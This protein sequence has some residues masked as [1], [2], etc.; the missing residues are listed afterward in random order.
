MPVMP[1]PAVVREHDPGQEADRHI[2]PWL[3]EKRG[4][5]QLE[6]LY[7]SKQQALWQYLNPTDR[8]SSTPA[9]LEDMLRVFDRLDRHFQHPGATEV[10][11]RYLVTASAIPGIFNLGG[12]LPRIAS[13]IRNRDRAGLRAYAHLCIDVQ[14]ARAMKRA[15]NYVSITLV[16][17][18]ALGGGFEAVLANDI[19]V[20]ERS[21]K[22]G[23]PEV[24]FN[25]FPGMG[26]LTFLTRRVGQ[27]LAERIVLSG[28]IYTAEQLHGMGL[29][30][31]LAEDGE[32]EEAVSQFIARRERQFHARAAVYAARNTIQPVTHREL[33]DITESWVDV[34]LQVDERDVR[35]MERLAAAQDKRSAGIC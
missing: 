4:L 30:D 23:M 8:P 22:F 2:L 10:P 14:F 20:A 21:A 27:T 13:L 19:I 1:G 32:G 18:D 33:V 17:G 29:V 34:A 25:M 35:K 28:E 12:D 15:Q 26:A 3:L 31:I 11:I 9:L 6:L 16:Q 5:S 24:L 7:D